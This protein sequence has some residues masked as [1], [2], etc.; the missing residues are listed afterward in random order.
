MRLDEM[1]LQ[2]FRELTGAAA[3]MGCR[4][5]MDWAESM[6]FDTLL[7]GALRH[8]TRLGDA[9]NYLDRV[10]ATLQEHLGFKISR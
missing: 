5:D 2:E 7:F 8:Y 6:A 10:A 4:T 3:M 9:L 1:R